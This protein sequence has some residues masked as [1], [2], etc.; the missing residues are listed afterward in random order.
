ML[1]ELLE[2]GAQHA[3]D[4]CS[5]RRCRRP[6]YRHLVDAQLLAKSPPFDAPLD[7]AMPVTRYRVERRD[8]CPPVPNDRGHFGEMTLEEL[9]LAAM[10]QCLVAEP[11]MLGDADVVVLEQLVPQSWATHQT[12]HDAAYGERLSIYRKDGTG[13]SKL[14][15]QSNIGGYDWFVLL[16]VAPLD[17]A[18]RTG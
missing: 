14:F 15:Q 6:L 17:R 9:A 10:G 8:L 2:T 12:V 16:L 7:P 11:A 5:S 1:S 13:W 3:P 4:D 18:A